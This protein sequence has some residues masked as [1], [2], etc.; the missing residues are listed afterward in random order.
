MATITYLKEQ[1]L[2]SEDI[3]GLINK[4]LKVPAKEE[5]K[6]PISVFNNEQLGSLEAIVKYLRENLKMAHLKSRKRQRRKK[7][8]L[9]TRRLNE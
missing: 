5:V 1:G 7:P 8:V 2:S 4:F 9:P 6:V 3:I